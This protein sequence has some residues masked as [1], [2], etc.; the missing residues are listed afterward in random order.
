MKEAGVVTQ[1]V[2]YAHRNHPAW[3][4]GRQGRLGSVQI[5]PSRPADRSDH[6]ASRRSGA[7]HGPVVF[8]GR[9]P[10]PALDNAADLRADSISPGAA[11]FPAPARARHA[12][13]RCAGQHDAKSIGTPAA[14]RALPFQGAG[15]S[16]K[17]AVPKGVY[18]WFTADRGDRLLVRV[19]KTTMTWIRNADGFWSPEMPHIPAKWLDTSTVEFKSPDEPSAR[20]NYWWSYDHPAGRWCLCN[21]NN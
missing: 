5:P 19:D 21:P 13:L 11:L 4:D 2:P 10:A 1:R 15:W 14:R 20:F 18:F 7:L 3:K 17:V 12:P 16:P 6:H 8:V 9:A